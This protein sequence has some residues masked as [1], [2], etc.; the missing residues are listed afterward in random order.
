MKESHKYIRDLVADG[1]RVLDMDVI[2]GT[3]PWYKESLD[4]DEAAKLVGYMMLESNDREQHE[5][6]MESIY[7][8]MFL[9]KCAA[10]IINRKLEKDA[11]EAAI[12]CAID[13]AKNMINDLLEFAHREYEMFEREDVKLRKAEDEFEINRGSCVYVGTD[14][15]HAG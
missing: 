12:K 4:I 10:A 15:I 7:T 1:R 11:M 5:F 6:L 9:V 14:P 3:R 2:M 13:Y 8:D